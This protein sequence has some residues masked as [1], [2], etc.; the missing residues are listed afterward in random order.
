MQF[1]S[2]KLFPLRNH[3][4]FMTHTFGFCFN[5]QFQIEL[6][7]SLLYFKQFFAPFILKMWSETGSEWIIFSPNNMTTH[8]LKHSLHFKLTFKD[9]SGLI[10]PALFSL[11]ISSVH[12]SFWKLMGIWHV[13]GVHVS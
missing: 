4:I 5:F 8:N 13:A 10:Y 7:M 2:L 6:F 1:L 11:H 12:N 9:C 3:Y